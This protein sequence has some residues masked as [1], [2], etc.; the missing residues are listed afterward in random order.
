MSKDRE[1]QAEDQDHAAEA[2]GE[3]SQA[4]DNQI[5]V[6]VR[7]KPDGT[8]QVESSGETKAE[9]RRRERA[10]GQR[11]IAEE[12]TKPLF[13]KVSSLERSL[14][15]LVPLLQQQHQAP[16]QAQVPKDAARDEWTKKVR[17]QNEIIGLLP[18]TRD[19]SAIDKLEQE[20]NDLE[21]DKQN[22]VAQAHAERA[23]QQFLRDN[24]PQE[25][26]EIRQLKTEF[27]DVFSAPG[28]ND[29][30]W[31]LFTQER[32]KAQRNGQPFDEMAAHRKVLKQTAEDLGIRRK[33]GSS[34]PSAAQQARFGGAGPT[35]NGHGSPT[36]SRPL[37][38]AERSM[39]IA[40]SPPGTPPD[41]AIA[42]WI[43]MV[44]VETL[45]ET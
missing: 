21:Y 17:R 40:A 35:S 28:G 16:A 30:A 41:K 23:R 38:K 18:T 39:A 7:E 43:N 42:A 45:R 13:D 9:R 14:A 24:P 31:G 19:K 29:Y 8:T 22:G 2:G 36:L 12:T 10:E 27:H 37:S 4:D 32:I 33:A 26:A 3:E 25:P 1:A 44:G 6:N 5:D 20:W 15:G 11:K 34:P